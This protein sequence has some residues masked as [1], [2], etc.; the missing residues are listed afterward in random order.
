M[1]RHG[2]RQRRDPFSV[3]GA[4][5]KKGNFHQIQGLA[6]NPDKAVHSYCHTF[7]IYSIDLSLSGKELAN[8][9]PDK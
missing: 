9:L 1:P 2:R 8:S 6:Q 7:I 5:S 4:Y 3:V